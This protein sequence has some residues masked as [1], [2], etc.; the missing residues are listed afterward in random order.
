MPSISYD[1]LVHWSN[2]HLTIGDRRPLADARRMGDIIPSAVLQDTG[3]IHTSDIPDIEGLE[4][5]AVTAKMLF[6]H[7]ERFEKQVNRP[8]P[9]PFQSGE[10]MAG[11]VGRGWSF[12]KL[13]GAEFSQLDC[14]GLSSV[15][16]LPKKYARK[17][18]NTA[19][20]VLC[21]GGTRLRE[22]VSWSEREMNV[23]VE[24]S[25]THLGMTVA[26]AFGTASHGSRLGF[27]GLQNSVLG[28]HIVTGPK[29]HV[30][31]EDP[32]RP[33]LSRAGLD[34]LTVDGIKCELISDKQVFED[35]L[36][37]L[38]SMGI[39]NG[40]ALNMAPNNTFAE[41]RRVQTIDKQWLQALA[42]GDF[43][44]IADRLNCDREPAFY[45]LTIDPLDPFNEPAAHICYFE[46]NEPPTP[47]TEKPL[48][49]TADVITGFAEYLGKNARSLSDK[50]GGLPAQ[51]S[52]D[53]W[54]DAAEQDVIA[55][56]RAM[57]G[58]SDSA[59]QFYKAISG[60]QPNDTPFD[61]D[62][63]QTNRK[64]WSGLHP[65][66]ITGGIPGS[67]YNASFSVKRKKLPQ[68]IEAIT[69]AVAGLLPTF[70]FTVRFVTKPRGTLAF[71]RFTENAVI[72]IDGLS[73][74]ICELFALLAQFDEEDALPDP[75]FFLAL[76]PTLPTGAKLVR[77]ALGTAKIGYSMHWAKLGD[78]DPA[79]VKA[80]FGQGSCGHPSP[81]DQ[82]RATR[83]RLL[84]PEWAKYFVNPE[85]KKLGLVP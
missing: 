54:T 6:A 73:P 59:F 75:R 5:F 56:I 24:T 61:P 31:I 35:A 84:G 30:W 9:N 43:K 26:G 42:A 72:E 17:P 64:K 76:A 40:V 38:G 33:V 21:S 8:K 80:D 4:R 11:M 85:V 19:R 71:T 2:Y 55:A 53:P 39:V 78:L 12:S 25:G 69:K 44:K 50:G 82:W 83:E 27:G 74:L 28:M 62:G 52:A 60:F 1:N 32:Q 63:S 81:I 37:H 7:L 13:I 34:A 66:E 57:L 46:T 36:I 22:L 79:K 3:D 70:V 15:S 29:S 18:L 45:E 77:Q 65:D 20:T 51:K 68:A 47:D 49:R 48:P 58:N 23:T 14:S 67:L 41:M 10:R 16:A